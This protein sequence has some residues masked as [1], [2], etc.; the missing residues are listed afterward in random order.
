[1]G[2]W[3]Q[4]GEG[5]GLRLKCV[6]EIVGVGLGMRDGVGDDYGLGLPWG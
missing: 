5:L 3:P 4:W 2:L 1:M 6:R